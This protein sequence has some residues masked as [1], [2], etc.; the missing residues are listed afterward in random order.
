MIYIV[1]TD[2]C[3]WISCSLDDVKNY[4]KIYEIKKRDLSKPLAIM[5]ESF[6]WLEKNKKIF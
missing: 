3:F 6:E 2:T 4:N 1:P 5:I